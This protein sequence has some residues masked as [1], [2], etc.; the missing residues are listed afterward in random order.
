MNYV[1]IWEVFLMGT[2]SAK[3]LDVHGVLEEQ[4]GRLCGWSRVSEGQRG[5]RGRD[6]SCGLWEIGVGGLGCV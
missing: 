4:R 5:R 2:A 6:R 3:A 1:E